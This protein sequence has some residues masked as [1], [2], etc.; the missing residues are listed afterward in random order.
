MQILHHTG[1]DQR[2]QCGTMFSPD[3]MKMAMDQMKNMTPEQVR[4]PMHG[5]LM[6]TR[7][8]SARSAQGGA[9]MLW[10]AACGVE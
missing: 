9:G 5:A 2:P 7:A 8:G 10:R 4:L 3:M 1:L 6:H